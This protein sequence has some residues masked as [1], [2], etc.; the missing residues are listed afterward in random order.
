MALGTPSGAADR[1]GDKGPLARPRTTR[2]V[3]RGSGLRNRPGGTLCVW[4][5]GNAAP[6][7]WS[8]DTSRTQFLAA[9]CT[10]AP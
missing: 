10:D 7:T 6:I 5:Q 3:G 9:P 1:P 4:N 8:S 2:R